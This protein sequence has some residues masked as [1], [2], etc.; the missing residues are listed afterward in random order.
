[1]RL[2]MGAGRTRGLVP[3]DRAGTVAS[4]A[5]EPTYVS[6]GS[7]W[8]FTPGTRRV[9]AFIVLI[10]VTITAM[11]MIEFPRRHG[12]GPGL[13]GLGGSPPACNATDTRGNGRN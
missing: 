6:V 3:V 11:T 9:D 13:E 2:A 1:M 10:S 12:H 7:H 5:T 4:A 8:N